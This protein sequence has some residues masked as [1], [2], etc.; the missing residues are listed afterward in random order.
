MLDRLPDEA[1]A[2]WMVQSH[3]ALG[4]SPVAEVPADRAYVAPRFCASDIE[5]EGRFRVTTSG[6][7]G[8]P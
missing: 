8:P 4:L 1:R 5:I 6:A 2:S 7:S 3:E